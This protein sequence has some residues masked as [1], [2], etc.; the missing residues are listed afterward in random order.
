MDGGGGHTA[1][2]PEGRWPLVW[3]YLTQLWTYISSKLILCFSV[4]IGRKTFN[5]FVTK[6]SEGFGLVV[7]IFCEQEIRTF[8]RGFM[9]RKLMFSEQRLLYRQ[10]VFNP[11][12]KREYFQ[13]RSFCQKGEA[14]GKNSSGQLH[15]TGALEAGDLWVFSSCTD[16]IVPAHQKT[17]G[18]ESKL[19]IQ[20]S[21]SW[22]QAPGKSLPQHQDPS[23]T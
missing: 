1:W 6:F 21:T 20:V 13:K 12:L 14:A 8:Y 23:D 2:A 7:D 5:M 3:I 18:L 17:G 11:P 22:L 16:L 9:G 15:S 10:K 19:Q 4:P